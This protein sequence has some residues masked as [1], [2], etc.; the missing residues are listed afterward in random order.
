MRRGMAIVVLLL[1]ILG[2]VAI[3]VGAYH[4]GV[5]HGLAQAATG[6]QVVRVIGPGWGFFP[7]GIFLFPLF[8]FLIF[9][10]M[11]VA[12]FGRRWH[13][14]GPG[15]WDKDHD[16]GGRTARFE[17]WHRRQHEQPANQAPSA[18]DQT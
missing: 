8:F 18:P 16:H 12:F 17:D 13:G 5:T 11:R 15:G 2:G 7:F 6:G 10:L 9:G 14:Y 4:A 3:G 1:A